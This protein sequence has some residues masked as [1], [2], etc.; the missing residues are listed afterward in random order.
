M[1]FIIIFLGLMPIPFFFI[2]RYVE[3]L[4]LIKR[5]GKIEKI[6]KKLTLS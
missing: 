2:G 5:K 6:A 4:R 1:I 3:R